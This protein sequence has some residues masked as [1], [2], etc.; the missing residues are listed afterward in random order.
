MGRKLL[1]FDID[2]TLW[3]FDNVIPGSTVEAIREAQANGHLCFINSGRSR[4]FIRHPALFAVGF[5]GI[6]SGCGTMIEYRDEVVLYHTLPVDYVEWVLEVVRKHSFRPI[7]EG[8]YHLYF[9]DED[10]K[11]DKFGAKI[12]EELGDDRLTI[13]DHWGQWE[14]S[15]LSCATKPWAHEACQ[16]ELGDDFDFMIHESTIVEMAPKGFSK[17]SGIERLCEILAVDIADTVCFGDS[18]NDLSMLQAAG[19]AVVM[20]NG[21]DEVK[22]IADFVTKDLHDEGIPYAMKE[23]KLI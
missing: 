2:G 6:V 11:D 3:D 15:K 22:K 5:D 17:A 12:I 14:I 23:L 19:T 10:F 8:R 7:L 4:C 16:K 18:V 9:D 21:M 1:F 20:G 13:A